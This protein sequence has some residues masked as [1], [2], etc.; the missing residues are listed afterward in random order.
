MMKIVIKIK[1]MCKN[2]GYLVTFLI[3]QIIPVLAKEV[4][5]E[6]IKKVTR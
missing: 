5:F 3:P 4:Q 1:H 6:E 2:P